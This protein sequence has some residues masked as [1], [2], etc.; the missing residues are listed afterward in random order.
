[1]G[2]PELEKQIGIN[3][4]ASGD[5]S[6][7][8]CIKNRAE[9][10]IVEEIFTEGST[11][12]VDTKP[13]KQIKG[14]GKY[15]L[16]VLVK[17]NWDNILVLKRIARNLHINPQRVSIAGL[18]DSRALTAQYLTIKDLKP[19]ELKK[20]HI[21]GI[22][23]TPQKIIEEPVSANMLWG[24][25]FQ[26]AVRD[27]KIPENELD[28]LIKNINKE[29]ERVGGFP[30]FYGYQRFGTIRPIT[31]EVGKQLIKGNI[32]KAALI[33]LSRSN[34]NE[35]QNIRQARQNLAD[36]LNYG[37]ALKEFPRHL[38]YERTMLYS[39]VE[40]PEDYIRAFRRLHIKLR[41]LFV[42]AY[43]AYL[44]NRILSKIIKEKS[45]KKY[46]LG[47]ALINPKI[48]VSQQLQRC[49]KV[50]DSNKKELVDKVKEGRLVLMIPVL[51]YAYKPTS[52][53][54]D[55]VIMDLL[56]EEGVS[57]ED[58]KVKNMSETKS[59]GK[60]RAA[61]IQINDLRYIIQKS[62]TFDKYSTVTFR[63]SLPKE[64]YATI[65]M[66]EFM[67]PTDLIS[68]GF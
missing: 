27:V 42:Q 14:N 65:V 30:N 56:K 47:D 31:H 53:N 40:K 2:I 61:L 13:T 1:L 51:G 16:T 37:K 17:Y 8:G 11:A 59:L 57:I 63:F 49:V 62:K 22:K 44:F 67:K 36:S 3:A 35:R 45:L 54:L 4:Y 9:D 26:I 48:S 29:V 39:L 33:F 25:Q 55:R 43:A 12:R 24:N 34:S 64:S 5:S 50:T 52:N 7:G 46:D 6:I 60:L 21:Q 19:Y 23:I 15:L 18:K 20:I 10:F 66:R 32:A 41:R 28:V 68:A 38:T 58:F